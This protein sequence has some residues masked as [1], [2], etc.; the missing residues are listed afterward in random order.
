MWAG[1]AESV[2][3][4]VTVNVPFTAYIVVKLDP[5]PVAGLPPGAL[6]VNVHGGVPPAHVAEKVTAVPTVPVAGPVTVTVRA[7]PTVWVAVAVFALE[8]V[9]VRVTLK[10]PGA[11]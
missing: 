4:A 5:L 1:D 7:P 10:G 11:V 6:H 8:S 2:P 3:V 9:V